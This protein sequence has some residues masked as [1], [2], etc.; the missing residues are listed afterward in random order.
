[1][2]IRLQSYY[3]S[4]P[5]NLP[6]QSR[7][8]QCCETIRICNPFL[9]TFGFF[10]SQNY[11]CVYASVHRHTDTHIHTLT[12]TNSFS[13]PFLLPLSN[14]D[15]LTHS[16]TIFLPP[17]YHTHP[18]SL[19]QTSK[20]FTLISTKMPKEPVTFAHISK[21]RE[22]WSTSASALRVSSSQVDTIPCSPTVNHQ[23]GLGRLWK[24]RDTHSLNV[25]SR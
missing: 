23:T 19:S 21:P 2:I 8:T 25:S 3:L 14:T 12:H 24:L 16:L 11:T 9:Y 22:P 17:Q 6:S 10:V 7:V 15:T 1:M 4:C 18:A 5:S 13:L 20:T